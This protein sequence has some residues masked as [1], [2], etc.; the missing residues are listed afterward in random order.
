[1]NS[2]FLLNNTLFR[3][4][5][6]LRYGFLKEDFTMITVNA[7]GVT[8]MTIYTIFYIYFTKEKGFILLEFFTVIGLIGIMSILVQIYGWA[9]INFLGFVCMSFNIVNFGAP[10]AGMRV[11]L[12]K[13]CCDSLPLPLCTANLLVSTQWFIYGFLVNDIYIIV[14]NNPLFANFVIDVPTYRFLMEPV[15]FLR[16]FNYRSSLS[17]PV[18][19]EPAHPF[20]ACL[21][22][23]TRKTKIL[24]TSK[25]VYPKRKLLC[26]MLK[27]ASK[28]PT[29]EMFLIAPC[30]LSGL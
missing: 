29:A 11:V 1:M 14:S 6:W 28:L 3:G 25:V 7:V 10:L 23:N 22:P 8:L 24:V 26:L 9:I 17:S 5:F 20:V 18:K 15:C 4:A 30:L 12:R 27:W 21:A 13:K 16:S 2:T 19:L